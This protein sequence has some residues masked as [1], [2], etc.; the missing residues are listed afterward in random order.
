MNIQGNI[1]KL[2]IG[3][4]LKGK[5]V[6]LESKT[7]YSEKAS[8]YITKHIFYERR[9]VEDRYGEEKEKWFELW[10]GYN[11]ANLLK[12]LAEYFKEIEGE[13]NEQ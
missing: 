3:I 2:L 5:N 12:Y 9:T 4:R 1:N 7:Y 11:K 10:S 6:K 13:A 8:N